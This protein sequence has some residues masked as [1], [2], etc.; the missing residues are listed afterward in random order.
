[1][2]LDWK[3]IEK[4]KPP[5]NTLL[6]LTGPSGYIRYKKFLCLGYYDED[7]RPS[8]GGRIRWQSVTNDSISDN[9]WYPTHWAYPIE[10]PE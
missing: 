8:H 9:G 10:L 7:F 3:E 6:T 1:M 5:E 2:K 4:C